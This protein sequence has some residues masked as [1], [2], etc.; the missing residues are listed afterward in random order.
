MVLIYSNYI[1]GVH[2]LPFLL[3]LATFT[4]KK[5][6]YL[7]HVQTLNKTSNFQIRLIGNSASWTELTL[8]PFDVHQCQFFYFQHSILFVAGKFM[9][10]I[11][12]TFNTILLSEV[13][14]NNYH[15]NYYP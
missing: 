15:N 9:V 5:N 6:Q 13:P 12:F 11:V 14:T 1:E 7:E 10:N 3:S 8:I 4:V 2:L